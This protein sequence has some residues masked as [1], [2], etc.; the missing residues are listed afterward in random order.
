MR[1]AVF[2]C[3]LLLSTGAVRAEK[4]KKDWQAYPKLTDS[5]NPSLAWQD[6]KEEASKSSLR[7]RLHDRHML[8]LKVVGAFTLLFAVGFAYFRLE[9]LARGSLHLALRAGF[10]V[11]V[12]AILAGAW[13][14][15]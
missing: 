9:E 3:G 15:L 7:D 4:A 13:W 11:C 10:V 14:I 12:L 5:S 6:V 1:L 2:L 8:W